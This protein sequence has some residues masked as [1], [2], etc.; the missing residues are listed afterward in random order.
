M[1]TKILVFLVMMLLIT[2]VLP[3]MGISAENKNINQ[4]YEKYLESIYT[5]PA[6]KINIVQTPIRPLDTAGTPFYGYVAYDPNGTLPEGPCYFMPTNPG[7]INSLAPTTS[8]SFLSGGTWANGIWY[9]CEYAN[10]LIWT[11]D[12]TTGVMTEV[13]SYDPGGTGLVFN[14]LAFDPMTNVLYGCNSEK[15]YTVS[16]SNGEST[17]VGTFGISQGWMIGIAFD[18]TGKLY[19]VDI[20]NDRTGNLYLINT[21]SGVATIVASLDIYI[22][23]AQDISFDLDTGI[24][25]LAAYTWQPVQEGALYECNHVTGVTTKLGTFENAAE[26]TCFAIPYNAPPTQPTI[27]GPSNGVPGTPYSWTFHSSDPDS[28]LIKYVV[29][30][31]DGIIEET[32]C[33]PPCTPITLTR[34][35]A[36]QGTYVIKAKAVDCP[37]GNLESAWSEKEV[38]IPRDKTINLN[39]FELLFERFSNSFPILKYVLS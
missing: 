20:S 12:E 30:W 9:G 28:S 17:L 29:D 14:G 22:V 13:G 6:D 11:I 25:Y 16:M 31:G 21:S 7:N 36:A 15:L 5:R 24:L 27:T 4:E 10:P 23:Y 38:T 34:T 35:Y 8:L 37:P 32:E 26:I 2:T 1:K 3:V 33:V 19:G 39:L 18:G